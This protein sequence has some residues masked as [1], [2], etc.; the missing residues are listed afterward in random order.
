MK[1]NISRSRVKGFLDTDGRRIVNGEG[2]EI[3]LTNY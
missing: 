1:K 2:E 3:L